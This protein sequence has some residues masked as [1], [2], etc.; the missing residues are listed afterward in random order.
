MSN[1]KEISAAIDEYIEYNEDPKKD[2]VELEKKSEKIFELISACDNHEIVEKLFEL[3]EEPSADFTPFGVKSSI[4][5]GGAKRAGKWLI[6]NTPPL[7]DGTSP[8][9]I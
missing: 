6:K 2:Q 8:I 3:L 9:L 5:V 4:A 1:L 7:P